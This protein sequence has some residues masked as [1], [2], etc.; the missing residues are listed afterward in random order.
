MRRRES[1]GEEL[2][3]SSS[4]T[5]SVY[6]RTVPS[7]NGFSVTIGGLARSRLRTWVPPLLAR[8]RA[9]NER[10]AVTDARMYVFGFY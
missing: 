3:R 2:S 8:S 6:M 4:K 5:I 7:E 9:E 1:R 10:F